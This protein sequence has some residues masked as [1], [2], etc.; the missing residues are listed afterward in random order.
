MACTKLI[1]KFFRI[2][3]SKNGYKVRKIYMIMVQK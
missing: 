2:F 1:I 3:R